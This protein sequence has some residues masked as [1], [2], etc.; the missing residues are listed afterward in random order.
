MTNE[1]VLNF[2]AKE[3][4]LNSQYGTV[5]DDR[6]YEKVME[7]LEKQIPKKPKLANN[8]YKQKCYWCPSC[9]HYFIEHYVEDW[10]NK[11]ML[12]AMSHTNAYCPHCG[13]AIDWS[14]V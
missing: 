14:K 7:L 12:E 4:M 8:I 9:S 10:F 1:E 2:I 3:R 6:V 13:Q 11:L 5:K